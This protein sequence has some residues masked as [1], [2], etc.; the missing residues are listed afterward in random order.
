MLVEFWGGFGMFY[1]ATL[2]YI[3]YAAKLVSA[4][5]VLSL[6]TVAVT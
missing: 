3:P 4:A 6:A 1:V 2:S 5:D